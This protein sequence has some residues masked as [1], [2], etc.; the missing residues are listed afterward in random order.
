MK[1]ILLYS[2]FLFSVA[3]GV[4]S[5]SSDE[6]ETPAVVFDP[7]L[8]TETQS[9]NFGVIDLNAE[10]SVQ[11]FTIEGL[12][13]KGDV[14][15]SVS[16]D[17]AISLEEE[18]TFS[19]SEITISAADFDAESVDIYVKCTGV[20]EQGTA[21]GTVTV[22][23]VDA[24]DVTIP[25]V[26]TVVTITGDLF[27][28]EYFNQY[29]SEWEGALPQDTDMIGWASATVA[30]NELVMNTWYAVQNNS[31]TLPSALAFSASTSLA[32]TGY[33]S[34]PEGA[35]S[36]LLMPD[37]SAKQWSVTLKNGNC[38]AAEWRDGVLVNNTGSMRRFAADGHTENVFMS[39]L[40]KVSD[41]GELIPEKNDPKGIG[42]LVCLGSTDAGPVNNNNV[43]VIALSDD[44]GGFNFGLQKAGE[45]NVI[46][47]STESFNLNE[48]YVV[49]V[50][51]EFVEGADNDITKLYV[52]AEGDEIPT[53]VSGLTPVATIEAGYVGADPIALNTVL[54]RE[55]RKEVV[56]STAE[57]TGI[58]VGSTWIAT[59]FADADDAVVS[60]DL[61]GRNI[62][63]TTTVECPPA[64]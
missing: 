32:L 18:G 20:G 41:L 60:N 30:G 61:T 1:K 16:G 35:R 55:R 48:T 10:S 5:C 34:A 64:E 26:A 40:V 56:T 28:S 14:T 39:S 15:V 3:G 54:I 51:H 6:S 53:D 42:D 59:L 24:D 43:K 13:L 31:V 63:N 36:I 50:S 57:I 47:T 23:T 45:G 62:A 27:I 2:L 37:H 25:L 58:R 11:K 52:F 7:E 8:S 44:N 22:G 12:D 4:A 38:K 29:G 21:Q 33:P 46:N 17:F 9:V 49:V 19:A